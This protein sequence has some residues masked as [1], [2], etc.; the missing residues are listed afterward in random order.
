MYYSHFNTFN[1]V[2]NVTGYVQNYFLKINTL[3]TTQINILK[4][5]T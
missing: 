3:Y 4:L 2:R 5:I 1:I